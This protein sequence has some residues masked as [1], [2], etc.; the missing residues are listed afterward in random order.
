[1]A[2]EL[3]FEEELEAYNQSTRA[4]LQQT[5]ETL[6]AQR[7]VP[8]PSTFVPTPDIEEARVAFQQ[9]EETLAEGM[10]T[11]AKWMLDHKEALALRTG[12]EVVGGIGLQYAVAKSWPTV[13]TFLQGT[14][15]ASML[16][17]AGPQAAEPASTVTGVLG[18][19]GSELLLKAGPWVLSNLGGQYVGKEIGLDKTEDYSAWEAVGAGLQ[20]VSLVCGTLR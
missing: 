8:T 5:Q 11:R 7:E 19:L 12:T 9:A 13:K 15:A 14:R 10:K 16:G 2:D 18:F 1:M 17:F 20:C 3:T 6:E 4:R